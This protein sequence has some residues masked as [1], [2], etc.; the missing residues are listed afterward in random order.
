MNSSSDDNRTSAE[1]ALR[2]SE[3]AFR[4]MV[5]TIPGLVAIMTAQGEVEY[6]NRQ[7]LEYFGRTLEELKCWGTS[8][9]VHPDDLPHVMAACRRSVETGGSYDVEHRILGANGAYR[10]FQSR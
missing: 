4:V 5:D 1:D 7:V 6:V 2:V 8:E 9:A 10:W 3:H